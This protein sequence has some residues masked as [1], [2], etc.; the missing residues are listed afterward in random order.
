LACLLENR[1]KVFSRAELISRVWGDGF[2]LTDR[3]VDSHVKA[4]RR[5]FAE[6]GADAGAIETVRGV[7]FRITSGAAR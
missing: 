4:L 7:G 6:A 1:G 2:A 5:K 3:T